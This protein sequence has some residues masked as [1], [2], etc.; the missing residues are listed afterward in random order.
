MVGIAALGMLV[1]LCT[2]R[3][4]PISTL[5][6]LWYS[7]SYTVPGFVVVRKDNIPMSLCGR[8]WFYFQRLF[9]YAIALLVAAAVVGIVQP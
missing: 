8:S 3:R 5:A 7:I 2:S 1:G 4:R 9:C 6:L